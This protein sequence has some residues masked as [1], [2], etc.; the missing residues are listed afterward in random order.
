MEMTASRTIVFCSNVTYSVVSVYA[1][2]IKVFSGESKRTQS[3]GS[4][5][6]LR[7][8]LLFAHSVSAILLVGKTILVVWKG[9]RENNLR[10]YQRGL[11]EADLLRNMGSQMQPCPHSATADAYSDEPERKYKDTKYRECTLERC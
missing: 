6:T 8:F 9:I 7:L 2:L 5:T 3:D 1:V 4:I 10:G 11:T